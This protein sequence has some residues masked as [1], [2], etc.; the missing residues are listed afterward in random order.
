MSW[1]TYVIVGWFILNAL[2]SI[3]MVDK[4]RE[5]VKPV[6]A[7]VAQFLYAGLIFVA[8]KSAGVL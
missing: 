7:V 8:L 2:F 5:P 4:E 3:G 1:P 6:G